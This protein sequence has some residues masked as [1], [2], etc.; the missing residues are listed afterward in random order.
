MIQMKNQP[1]RDYFWIIVVFSLQW[2]QQHDKSK[3]VL[4]YLTPLCPRIYRI[5]HIAF[6]RFDTWYYRLGSNRN[7]LESFE[8]SS[9]RISKQLWPRDL[10]YGTVSKFYSQVKG[11]KSKYQF[12][13]VL[14]G[15]DENYNMN[16]NSMSQLRKETE[17]HFEVTFSQQKDPDGEIEIPRKAFLKSKSRTSVTFKL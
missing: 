5:G 4:F 6:D 13:T 11:W 17:L 12:Y 8:R 2:I 9:I 14:P 1:V 3:M 7:L 10:L 15:T 16:V